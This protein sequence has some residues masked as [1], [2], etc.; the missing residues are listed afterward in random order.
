MPKNL[1]KNLKFIVGIDEAG[2]GPLA[3]PVAVGAV[4]I[5]YNK[6]HPLL[7]GPKD[8]KQISE[9]LRE[10]WFEKLKV[11][12]KEGT[13]GYHV[14]LVSAKIIDEKGIV[15]AI[16]IAV[17]RCLD[18]LAVPPHETMVL[19]DG[20]LYAPDY[21]LYQKTIIRGDQTEPLIS[22]ASIAAKVTRDRKMVQLSKKYPLYDFHIH[23]GYG[24]LS[25]RKAIK[26]FGLCDVHRRSFLKNVVLY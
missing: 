9:K 8:S 11:A 12:E 18:K 1:Q 15:P 14:S 3:G 7:K 4:V 24:T 22:L 5:P 21:F 23:K 26:K 16:K 6:K 19:L 10:E 25:H 20:S 2:R 13:L 17:K